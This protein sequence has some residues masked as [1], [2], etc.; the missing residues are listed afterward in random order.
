MRQPF[1]FVDNTTEARGIRRTAGHAFND[2]I[3]TPG[4]HAAHL[5]DLIFIKYKMLA[6]TTQDVS[7]VLEY[8]VQVSFFMFKSTLLYN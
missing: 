8:L 7:T 3:R 6:L 2:E 4:S 1:C 5:Q